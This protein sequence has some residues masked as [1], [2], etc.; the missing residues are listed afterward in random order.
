MMSAEMAGRLRAHCR[1]RIYVRPLYWTAQHLQL[2]DCRFVLDNSMELKIE[3]DAAKKRV[4][5]KTSGQNQP[6]QKDQD[7]DKGG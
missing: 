3:K 5:G 1:E 6:S 7:K 4:I 2:L